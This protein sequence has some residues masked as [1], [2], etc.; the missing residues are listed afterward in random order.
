MP[1]TLGVQALAG[2]SK[3]AKRLDE[4]QAHLRPGLKEQGFKVRGRTFNRPHPDGLVDVVNFQM[5]PYDLPTTTYHPGLRENLY[6]L[7]TVNLGVF[8]PEV[9]L[10]ADEFEPKSWVQE[11]HCSVRARLGELG[12]EAED[13]WWPLKRRWSR[14]AATIGG[15]LEIRAYPFFQRFGSREAIL[16]ELR[17]EEFSPYAHPTSPIVCGTLMA[18]SGR[19]SE[20]RALLARQTETADPGHIEYLEE[21]A[22]RLGLGELVTPNKGMQSV[23]AKRCR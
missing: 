4:I 21:V 16:S 19:E 7:F 11:Y 3:Y 15:L 9:A 1:P 6:G 10:Y 22:D 5:G 8:V 2:K 14:V 18:V 23:N 20:A 12:P 17:E 13:A